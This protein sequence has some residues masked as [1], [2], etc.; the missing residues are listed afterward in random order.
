ME[1]RGLKA[2]CDFI[3]QQQSNS[4]W[5]TEPFFFTVKGSSV[6]NPRFCGGHSVSLWSLHPS[7]LR[8]WC[9]WAM[10]RL[11][12]KDVFCFLPK[13]LL[14]FLTSSLVQWKTGDWQRTGNLLYCLMLRSLPPQVS[15]ASR[16]LCLTEHK[17]HQVY[18]LNH[19]FQNSI[20]YL[21]ALLGHRLFISIYEFYGF[22][23]TLSFSQRKM[24]VFK[25]LGTM[26]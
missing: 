26:F 15:S 21:C 11:R 1:S 5:A 19:T 16:W 24:Y 8:N 23:F 9:V 13:I 4:E 20:N 25:T 14:E 18:E 7:I 10:C 12:P 17:P 3:M 2:K 6:Q 22:I